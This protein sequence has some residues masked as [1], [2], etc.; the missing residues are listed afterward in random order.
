MHP[1][2]TRSEAV[3]RSGL[4][5]GELH[6]LVA[7]AETPL[8]CLRGASLLLTGATGWFGVWLLDTLCAA[9]DLLGLGLRIHAVSRAPARF[10]ARFPPFARDPRIVWVAAD[11]RALLPTAAGFSHV[12]HAATDTSAAPGGATA[13]QLYETIVEGTRRTLAAAGSRCQGF[14]YLS[15]GAVYGPLRHDQTGFRETDAAT[16]VEP[17]YFAAR[18][19]SAAPDPARTG[20]AYGRGKR[21]AEHLCTAAAAR[22]LPVRIAR[23][24]AFVGPHMP[25]DRHFAIG[26]FIADAVAGRAIRVSGDGRPLRSYLYMTDLMRALFLVLAAGRCGR[27][28]NVGSDI[29]VSIAALA[30][31]VDRNAGGAGV[32]IEGAASD[33][34]DRYVPD[35]TRLQTEL[36]FAAEVALEEA[37]VR[38]AAWLRGTEARRT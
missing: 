35:T 34:W 20:S 2:R 8:R 14:L 5:R 33:P 24:F 19:A 7:A 32:H 21:A 17:D 25:F 12:I 37:I 15:S 11:V 10:L 31:C 28:Y 3:S 30:H 4:D 6:A 22:G 13:E 9:D 1:L 27:A 18:R 26:N 29:A 23:C 38:T 36:D 16:D